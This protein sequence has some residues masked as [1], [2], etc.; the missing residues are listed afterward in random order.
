MNVGHQPVREKRFVKVGWPSAGGLW[1]VEFDAKFAGVD[2]EDE[3]DK[4]LMENEGPARLRMART[5]DERCVILRYR[6]N[7]TFSTSR[8]T[9]GMLF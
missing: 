9:R 3:V 2:E 1:V 7:D 6:F 4:L 5:M 8:T